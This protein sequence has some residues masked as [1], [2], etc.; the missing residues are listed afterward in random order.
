MY[1][2]KLMLIQ[3]LWTLEYFPKYGEVEKRDQNKI[4][5]FLATG[6]DDYSSTLLT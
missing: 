3:S 5:P 6:C 1:A 4:Q 2:D